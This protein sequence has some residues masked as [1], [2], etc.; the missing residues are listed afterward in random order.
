MVLELLVETLGQYE[1]VLLVRVLCLRSIY[2]L[3]IR[4]LMRNCIAE[5]TQKPKC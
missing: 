4:N 1:S 3:E 5:S 2:D